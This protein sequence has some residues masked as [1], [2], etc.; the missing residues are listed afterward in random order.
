[1]LLYNITNKIDHTIHDEWLGWMQQAYIPHVMEAG[2]FEDYKLSRLLGVDESDGITYALQFTV[3]S[4]PAFDIYQEKYAY[5]HQQMHDLRYKGSF[6]TF[7]S[8]LSVVDHGA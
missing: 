4:R 6:V 2:V 1:M 8:L 7:R 3:S 5:A